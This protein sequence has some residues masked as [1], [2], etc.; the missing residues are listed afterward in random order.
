MCLI[1]H[2]EVDQSDVEKEFFEDVWKRNKDG[3]GIMWLS[4]SKG[5]VQI[6]HKKG[7]VFEDF[8]SLYRGLEAENKEM[9]IHFR[10]RTDGD[11]NV[12]MCHPFK[13]DDGILMMHNGVIDHPYEVD[14]SI[15]DTSAFVQQ[16]I[17]PLINSMP[18]NEEFCHMIGIELGS[19]EEFIRSHWFKCIVEEWCGHNNKLAFLDSR[20]IT[21]FN[22][23]AWRKTTFGMN[24]SNT[25]AYDHSNPTKV[26]YNRPYAG[27]YY[28][29]YNN[30]GSL[31]GYSGGY[32]PIGYTAPKKEETTEKLKE[33]VE[34][35][36][37][38]PEDKGEE[39]SGKVIDYLFNS[40]SDVV[41]DDTFEPYDGYSYDMKKI[42]GV[43]SMSIIKG[44]ISDMEVLTQFLQ[45][46]G[47]S[48][49][50]NLIWSTPDLAAELITY[51]LLE[52]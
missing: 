27:G 32:K 14:K 39:N 11:I 9:A 26:S 7:L 36:E 28:N 8:W 33:E 23:K 46:N 52:A 4:E 5:E 19:R 37:E 21:L 3:W 17:V 43:D 30:Y 45:T 25:Y 31:G 1:M 20:G 6:R 24:C 29:S 49:V 10:M 12:S 44:D 22:N 13:V 48:E 42:L 18:Q 34:T 35:K 15:S 51:L 41:D 38:E 47:D 40:N 16:I 2:R 50:D